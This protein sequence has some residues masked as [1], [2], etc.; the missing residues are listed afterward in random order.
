MESFVENQ[1]LSE[2]EAMKKVEEE[3]QKKR[4]REKAN[5]RHQL[6]L[7]S[8][9]ENNYSSL[10]PL[11]WADTR[12]EPYEAPASLPT[13]AAPT[14]TQGSRKSSSSRK[15]S[16]L[17]DGNKFAPTT[18]VLS[19][20]REPMRDYRDYRHPRYL[21]NFHNLSRSYTLPVK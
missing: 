18:Q 10:P 6:R 2:L 8:L 16:G 5:I 21:A 17:S 4:A 19:E 11:E 15:S 20:F 13:S 7:F 12:T 14:H 9:E 1:R 3:F